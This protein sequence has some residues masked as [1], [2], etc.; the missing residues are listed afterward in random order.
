ML[1][2]IFGKNGRRIFDGLVD[3]LLA[4]CRVGMTGV[5]LLRANQQDVNESLGHAL[6]PG[7]DV[8]HGVTIDDVLNVALPDVGG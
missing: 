5:I 3:R 8:H 2:D 7:L 1:T 4:A 6:R